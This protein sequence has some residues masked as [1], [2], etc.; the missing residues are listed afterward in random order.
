MN[1]EQYWR[2]RGPDVIGLDVLSEDSAARQAATY[3]A[4][5]HWVM[6]TRAANVL[7]VG[8][9][10]AALALYLRQQGYA[11]S[12]LGVDSNAYALYMVKREQ[13][14][15]GNLR[16]LPFKDKQFDAVVVKDVIEH[17]EDYTPL[18]EAFRVASHSAIVA[19]YLPWSTEAAVIERHPDLYFINRYR[20]SDIGELAADCGFRLVE[21]QIIHESNGWP[22]QVVRWERVQ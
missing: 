15:L 7:D 2:N 21:T 22:N 5:A 9:N 4:I 3:Q 19:T 12:Y 13:A 16:A 17:L 6:K 8:C 18:R 10:V 1:P 11:G 14:T 20:E